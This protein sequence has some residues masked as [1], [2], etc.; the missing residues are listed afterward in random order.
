M[1]RDERG[2]ARGRQAGFA[3]GN[4]VG[5]QFQPGNTIGRDTRFQP[6][7]TLGRKFEPGNTMGFKPGQSVNPGGITRAH[8][9][10][11]ALAREDPSRAAME[12]LTELM[13]S[14]DDPRAVIAAARAVLS[15]ASGPRGRTPAAEPVVQL[16]RWLDDRDFDKA[17]NPLPGVEAMYDPARPPRADDSEDPRD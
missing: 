16:V 10:A 11:L 15:Y 7:N 3:P 12:R 1:D 9:A 4:K 17:G 5:R 2:Q 6:G 14:C 13:M 8:R